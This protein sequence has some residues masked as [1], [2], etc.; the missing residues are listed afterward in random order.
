[1]QPMLGLSRC[2]LVQDE[3]DL[4]ETLF[5]GWKKLS[6]GG[7]EKT[8]EALQIFRKAIELDPKDPRAHNY[9][10]IAN[11]ILG[12]ESDSKKNYADADRYCGEKY[13]GNDY[14]ESKRA[15]QNLRKWKPI[16]FRNRGDAEGKPKAKGTDFLI[17]F[18]TEDGDFNN[19]ALKKHSESDVYFQEKK[20]H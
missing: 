16:K 2:L 19:E 4:T 7:L 20:G 9:C 12:E 6:E 18:Q 5:Q 15:L 17:S 13:A 10:G 11:E 14:H 8:S 1:M 3:I